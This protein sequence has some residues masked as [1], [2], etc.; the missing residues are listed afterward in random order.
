[1]SLPL[2]A[3]QSEVL[4]ALWAPRRQDA[5]ERL[6]PL[7]EQSAAW[8]R[9]LAAY[10]SHGL[11][12]AGR[13]LAQAYPVI[14][15]LVG[16]EAFVAL[17]RECW[18][19]HPPIEGDLAR[20]GGDLP[21]L[22]RA[23]PGLCD[24]EPYLPDVARV[25]GCLHAAGTA[26]DVLP[27]LPSLSWLSELPLEQLH[28]RLVPGTAVVASEYPVASIVLANLTA[29]P[30]LADAGERLRQGVAEAAVV[31]RRGLRPCVRQA[32][33]GEA[34]FLGALLAGRSLGE[35]LT[36]SARLDFHAWLPAAVRSGL[37]LGAT[38]GDPE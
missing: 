4:A 25:E 3:L 5:V 37:L 6:V 35:A 10:R 13:V 32:A 7:V 12:L 27:D 21:E 15:Q 24:E 17:A 33:P 20:W 18:L 31:W 19:R 23:L 36:A 22:I 34:E 2:A 11:A 8:N 26:D 16:D 28:L 29:E 14:G 9:G 38:P 1:M 30:S